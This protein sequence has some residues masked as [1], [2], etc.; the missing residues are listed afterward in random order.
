MNTSRKY[1]EQIVKLMERDT[2]NVKQA[3]IW[4]KFSEVA[5]DFDVI[6]WKESGRMANQFRARQKWCFNNCF[7][8]A[9][10]VSTLTYYEGFAN[11]IIP[12]GHAWLVR[13]DGVVIDPTLCLLDQ[14][15]TPDYCGVPV[16]L[17]DAAV[18]NE[19]TP[20]WLP[21]VLSLLNKEEKEK[22]NHG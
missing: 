16:P 11:P 8:I 14:H 1:V 3:A 19:I 10:R 9:S 20:G 6:D 2:H 15:R 17:Q 4:K 22:T 12:I 21:Y 7:R 5:T 13:D 18:G